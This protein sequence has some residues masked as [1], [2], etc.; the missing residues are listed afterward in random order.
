MKRAYR[1]RIAVFFL[2]G[3][4]VWLA[5]YVLYD[6]WLAPR[7]TWDHWLCHSLVLVSGEILKVTGFDTFVHDRVVGLTG[8]PGIIIINPCNGMEAMGLFLGFVHA[9]PGQRWKR[10]L[11]SMAGLLVI[12]MTNIVRIVVLVLIQCYW[13]SLFDFTHHYSTTAIFYAIVF[14]LWVIWAQWGIDESAFKRPDMNDSL[15]HEE[16]V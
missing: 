12:Y 14:L 9:F 3:L 11:F 2:R 13:F 16:A 1:K 8:L 5:W 4:I 10:W 6:L 15:R 7:G